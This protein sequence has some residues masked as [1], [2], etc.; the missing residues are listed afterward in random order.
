MWE[1]DPAWR[2]VPGAAGPSTTGLW[3][4]EKGGRTWVVKRLATPDGS[5]RAWRPRSPGV[6]TS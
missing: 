1:P 3:L 2:D 6:R 5:N 4:A